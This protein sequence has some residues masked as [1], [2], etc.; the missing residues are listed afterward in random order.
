MPRSPRLP[1][2]TARRR[3]SCRSRPRR[4][5]TR[6]GAVRRARDRGRRAALQGLVTP[7]H[8]GA[9]GIAL[10]RGARRD[11][12]DEPV[13][14]VLA[15]DEPRG[16]R[17]LF[18][19]PPFSLLLR[20]RARLMTHREEQLRIDDQG[21]RVSNL[22]AT[23]HLG[24]PKITRYGAHPSVQAWLPRH[25]PRLLPMQRRILSTDAACV[26]A[27]ATTQARRHR[28]VARGA[29][30]G[31]ASSLISAKQLVPSH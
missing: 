21:N 11:R 24:S 31:Q 25:Q 9:P 7:D 10:R 18:D 13:A 5:R 27:I 17:G 15:G 26:R 28:R 4:S 2:G 16:P 19:V 12:R 6:C 29:G 3:S 8:G 30:C 14:P 22:R 20:V 1:R 23:S